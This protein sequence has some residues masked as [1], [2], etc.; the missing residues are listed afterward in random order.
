MPLP[1]V[2]VLVAVA[3]LL[4]MVVVLM[5]MP[6]SITIRSFL[7]I[8]SLIFSPVVPSTAPDQEVWKAQQSMQRYQYFI[9]EYIV[10]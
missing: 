3:L 9:Y 6:P 7:A 5:V 10:L 2:V 4:M 1:C 8:A